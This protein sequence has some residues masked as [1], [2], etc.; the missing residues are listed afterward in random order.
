MI[1]KQDLIARKSLNQQ[2]IQQIKTPTTLLNKDDFSG[3]FT[4][5]KSNPNYATT[6]PHFNK[7]G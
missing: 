7:L 5:D 2:L 3:M 6:Q 1:L 4:N